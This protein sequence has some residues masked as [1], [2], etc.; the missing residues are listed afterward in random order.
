[1]LQGQSV[2]TAH[3]CLLS[4]GQETEKI[5]NVSLLIW[6]KEQQKYN[7]LPWN[8]IPKS[9]KVKIIIA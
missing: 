8:K 3:Q 7:N 2:Y 5:Q 1:M 4:P 9:V 6:S